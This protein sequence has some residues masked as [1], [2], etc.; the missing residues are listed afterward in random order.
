MVRTVDENYVKKAVR[1]IVQQQQQ[2]QQTRPGRNQI[3]QRPTHQQQQTRDQHEAQTLGNC[4]KLAAD[5]FAT[6][7]KFS[8][9]TKGILV[10][11]GSV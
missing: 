4:A 3:A 5:E 8:G 1:I 9:N 11:P 6:L 7:G 10:L 2:Q